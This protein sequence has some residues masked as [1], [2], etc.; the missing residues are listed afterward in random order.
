M[1][2]ALL[3]TILAGSLLVLV[4]GVYALH[5]WRQLWKQ[6]Q[7]L[8]SYQQEISEKLADD[9]RILCSSL[10]DGQMP[11]VEGCIRLKVILEHYNFELSHEEDYAVFQEVFVATEHIPTHEG[12]KALDKTERRRHEATFASLEEQ[13]RTRS[14][15]AARQLL[16]LLGGPTEAGSGERVQVWSPTACS[17]DNTTRHT[18]H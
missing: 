2:N 15:S 7:R 9:L 8:A 12:W 13:F 5:V 1:D 3:L 16:T 6:R 18:L 4:L 14:L 11:W 17:P 10:L